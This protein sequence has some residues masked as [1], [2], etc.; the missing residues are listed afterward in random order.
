MVKVTRVSVCFSLWAL[1]ALASAQAEPLEWQ[2]MQD[3][4]IAEITRDLAAINGGQLGPAVLEAMR[5]TPRHEFVPEG[6]QYL[7]YVN[8]PLPI[9]Q[10][11]TI[12]QPFIVAF[13]TD[14]LALDGCGTVLEVGTGSGYQAAV[15]AQLCQQVYTIEIIGDLAESAR[16]RL[17]RLGYDNVLVRHGDGMAGWAEQAPF[18]GIMVTAAG[19]EVPEALIAQLKPGARLVM[20]VGPPGEVQQ[21]RVVEKSDQGVTKTDVLPV[22]FVPVTQKVR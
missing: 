13:M 21:L 20:P 5:A 2:I 9:G 3:E 1:L 19:L 8:R 16:A 12:S 18:D 14:L 4:L 22:V 11:Q 7:A 17:Q 15:L 6:I 10:E